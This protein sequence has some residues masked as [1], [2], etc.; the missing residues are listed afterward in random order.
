MLWESL[1]VYLVPEE[2][3]VSCKGERLEP[4]C[5]LSLPLGDILETTYSI[6]F[7]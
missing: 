5:R 1:G 7:T 3:E 4:L 6:N 2:E